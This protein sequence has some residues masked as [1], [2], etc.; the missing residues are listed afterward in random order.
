MRPAEQTVSTAMRREFAALNLEDRVDL[1]DSVMRLG[2][3]RHLPV[4]DAAGHVVGVVSNRDL[5]EASLSSVLT[6]GPAERHAF[7]RSVPVAD[8]MTRAV[9]TIAPGA[10]LATA[11]SRMLSHKIGCLPVVDPE[12]VMVGLL[13]ES[14]LLAIAYGESWG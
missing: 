13:T 10:L 9:E 14:D 2:R 1:A 11:A 6:L 4:L 8:V 5:L 7:L 3:V 12:G